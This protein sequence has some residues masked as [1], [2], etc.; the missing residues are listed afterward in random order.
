MDGTSRTVSTEKTGSQR[1]EPQ[2]AGKGR[3]TYKGNRGVKMAVKV[4]VWPREAK[5][6]VINL[7]HV[8]FPD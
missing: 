8:R 5:R 4:I 1:P 3:R 6:K 2:D 7:T